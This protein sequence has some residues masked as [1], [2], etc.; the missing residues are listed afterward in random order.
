MKTVRP[1]IRSMSTSRNEWCR[2]RT[3]ARFRFQA[4]VRA[5]ASC[6]RPMRYSYDPYWPV[7]AKTDGACTAPVILQNHD[8]TYRRVF[9]ET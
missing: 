7:C 9:A 2:E 8:L 3:V 1:S 4:P 6:S 5:H